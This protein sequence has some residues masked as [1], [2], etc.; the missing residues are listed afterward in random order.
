M[1]KLI[2]LI[3]VI[4]LT[5]CATRLSKNLYSV[6]TGMYKTQVISLLGRPEDRQIHG[7]TEAWQYCDKDQFFL[8]WFINGRVHSAYRERNSYRGYDCKDLFR[9][10]DWG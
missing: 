6:D 4:L 5:S 1:K 10:I 8:I 7:N 2:I 9:P 3:S